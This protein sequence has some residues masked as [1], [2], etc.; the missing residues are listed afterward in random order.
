MKVRI[1]TGLVGRLLFGRQLRKMHFFLKKE[2][3]LRYYQHHVDDDNKDELKRLKRYCRHRLLVYSITEDRMERSPNYR[4]RFFR[5]CRGIFGSR[6]YLC[7]YCGRPMSASHT[8]VDHIIPV[9]KAGTSRYYQHLLALRHIRN[10]NDIRNLAPSCTRCNLEKSA[11]GGFWVMRGFFGRSWLRKLLWEILLLL[12]GSVL[13][14]ALYHFLRNSVSDTL[15]PAIIAF[16][17]PE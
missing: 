3:G 17:A 11:Y 16:F 4:R 6:F 8:V 14:Y 5:E 10:V 7:A 1:Y 2:P 9:Y 13:L 12:I 15:V